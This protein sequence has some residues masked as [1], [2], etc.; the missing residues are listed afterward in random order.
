[1]SI[2][3]TS[4]LESGSKPNFN[5]LL[6]TLAHRCGSYAKP[7]ALLILM[8]AAWQ[9][10]V[11]MGYVPSIALASPTTTF[12]YIQGHFGF[13]IENS[14]AT[15]KVIGLG[16]VLAL[17][18]GMILGMLITQIKFLE[19]ALLPLLIVTQVIPSIAIAPLLVLLLGFGDAPKIA[20]AA[21]IGFFPVL[22]NTISGLR[23]IDEDMSDLARSLRASSLQTLRQ[24]TI[25]NALPYIFAGARVAITLSVIG[26]VVG[27][28]VTADKGLGYLILQGSATLS[29]AIIFAALAFLA[30]IG[31]ALFSAVRILE[32][33][34][35]PWARV[36]T[37]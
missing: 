17:A 23:S 16:F 28:F 11:D 2:R 10:V 27:E 31:I 4:R 3:M 19:D 29:P 20:T 30:I 8:L 18:I 21:S 5:R 7:G 36:Q 14:L 1:M 33:W 32:Y 24:F 12:S 34:L 6:A 35:V 22:I 9:F 15:L 13:L 26:A 37:T 25:P